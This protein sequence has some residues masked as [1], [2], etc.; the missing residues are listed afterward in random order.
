MFLF[1]EIVSSVSRWPIRRS[2]F[3]SLIV[4]SLLVQSLSAIFIFG[5]M[6]GRNGGMNL[7][8]GKS[9]LMKN[10]PW[11][12]LTR[13]ELNLGSMPCALCLGNH[14]SSLKILS[15]R[16]CVLQLLLIMISAKVMAFV[17]SLS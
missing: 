13:R 11:F 4:V 16:Q 15:A 5:T 12:I 6:A 14:R 17:C 8:Y 3:F 2:A 10:G 1:F 7:I 9:D